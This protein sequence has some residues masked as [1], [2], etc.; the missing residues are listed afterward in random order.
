MGEHLEDEESERFGLFWPGKRE[1]RRLASMPSKGTLVP[2]PGEG[3]NEDSTR[4]IFIEGENLEVLKL[5][6]KSYAGRVK[7][8]YI[9]PPYNTGNDFVYSDDYAEPLDTYLRRGGQFGEQG[10][11]LTTNTRASGRYHS[12]WL[13]MMHPRLII[14]RELVGEDGVIFVSID[15]NEFPR[16]RLLLD[17][18]FGEENFAAQITVQTNP[19]GRVLQSHFA[20]SHDYLLVYAKNSEYADFSL[21]KTD[22]EVATDYPDSDGAGRYRLLE[23]RNTHRQFGRHNRPNLYYP[24][25]VETTT[26]TVSLDPGMS[27]VE[28]RPIW[29]DGFEGCWTW[30]REKVS[31]EINYLVGRQVSDRWKVYR[32]A[33]GSDEEGE[34]VRKKL[35]TIWLDPE[36]QTE[37]GQK[38]FDALMGR[39]IFRAPK[40]VAL[41]KKLIELGC[42][43]GGLIVDFFAGSCTTG[44]ATLEMNVHDGMARNFILVQ[45]PEPVPMDSPARGAKLHTIAEIGKERIRRVAV[46][47]REKA[48]SVAPPT[49]ATTDLGFTVFKLATSHFREW[50]DYQGTDTREYQMRLGDIA[51]SPLVDGWNK[52]S[53]L[54]EIMLQEGFPLD[55]AIAVQDEFR[56]REIY[57]L[58]SE[59][60]N[61]ALWVCLDGQ[62][63]E[64]TASRLPHLPK[65]DIFICLDSAL[66]DELK[67][68]LGDAINLHVI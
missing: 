34:V 23:L 67:M 20:Q 60:R 13:S 12:N 33:Y 15:D 51:R 68:R 21:K 14:A 66:T 8:I 53:V 59:A 56:P 46:K 44:E 19:K 63:G 64:E 57:S 26:S 50:Q 48:S 61:F 43:D 22:E 36:F 49:K 54:I 65:D 31:K 16:L 4:N 41:I 32:K 24:L 55:S 6:Q 42:D 62:I 25:F 11:L 9:D 37:R 7:M 58:R 38:E 40:P 1:A 47:L 2:A 35:K 52:E 5:L 30:S 27:T 10:E 29:D 45:L 3:V 18:V 17:E 39:G 28:V